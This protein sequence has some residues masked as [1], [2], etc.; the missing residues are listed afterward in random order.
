M[1]MTTKSPL[2]PRSTLEEQIREV[3]GVYKKSCG[4]LLF[5]YDFE[6]GDPRPQSELEP[7][8]EQVEDRMREIREGIE[9]FMIPV[10]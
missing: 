10:F 7:L 6:D 1:S 5:D 2:P 9:A 3:Q 4:E 8:T